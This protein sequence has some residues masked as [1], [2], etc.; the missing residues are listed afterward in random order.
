MKKVKILLVWVLII[1][2]L[3]FNIAQALIQA[4]VKSERIPAGTSFNV[5]METPVNSFNYSVGDTFRATLLDDIR[6]GRLIVLPAGTALRGTVDR[7]KSAGF[8][9]RGGELS[10]RFDHAVTPFGKQIPLSVK[11]TKA[12][13]LR[14]DGI[15]SAGG[16][17][18]NALGQN[19]DKGAKILTTTSDYMYNLGKS[20][21]KGIPV[22]A[23]APLGVF[24]GAIG[25]G[26]Y[27]VVKSTAD[28]FKKGNDLKINPGDII[29]VT[30]T[31][32]L[33]VPTN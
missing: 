3:T 32:P 30:L 2:F 21:W 27:F 5:R 33:D 9:C 25:G 23:T 18:M 29:E 16:G 11:T 6:I 24:A 12:L 15:F 1:N 13:N 14:P 26:G 22:I 10:L 28:M 17:Y 19:G 31:E 4:D 7:A 20:F 8:F